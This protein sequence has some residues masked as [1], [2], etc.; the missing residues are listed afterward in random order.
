[1]KFKLEIDMDNAAFF[2]EFSGEE[3]RDWNEVTRILQTA[4]YDINTGNESG[5]SLYDHNGNKVG[6]WEV[7][8]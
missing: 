7:T 8:E 1:M 3:I 2:R 5:H 4:I 6:Q